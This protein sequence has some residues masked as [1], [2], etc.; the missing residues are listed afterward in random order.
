MGL[1]SKAVSIGVVGL[2]LIGFMGLMTWGLINKTLVTGQSGF[3]RVQ[4]PARDFTLPLFNGGELTLSEHLG[5]PVV[6]NFWASWC[7]PCRAEA[8]ALERTWR[9]YRDQGVLFVGVNVQDSE[10]DAREYL[11]DFDVTYPNGPDIDGRATVGYGGIGLPVT[12]FVNKAGI[13]ERRWLGAV[14]EGQLVAWTD[15]LVA[16]IVPS[17]EVEG[18]NWEDFFRLD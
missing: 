2:A 14:K 16:G 6:I 17:G 10:E 13:I 1:S 18:E 8:P 9:A 3:T 5:R 11:R 7:P 12:F 15:E 4:E